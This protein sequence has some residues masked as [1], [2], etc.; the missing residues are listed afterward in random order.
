MG[1]ILTQAEFQ[2]LSVV[3][4][5]I[6]WFANIDNKRTRRAYQIDIREFMAFTEIRNPM[7]FRIVTR[8]H[9]LTTL[10]LRIFHIY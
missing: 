3:P 9:S 7:E 10:L 5:E 8:A 6:E 2:N 4:A 1:G